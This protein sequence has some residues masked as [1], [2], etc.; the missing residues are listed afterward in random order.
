MI[1]LLTQLFTHI[2]FNNLKIIKYEM[3]ELDYSSESPCE[4]N[5][6]FMFE[7]Y[8]RGADLKENDK[9]VKSKSLKDFDLG[10]AFKTD[11][12]QG[13]KDTERA[14]KASQRKKDR[15]DSLKK[16]LKDIK[17]QLSSQ[18]NLNSTGLIGGSIITIPDP[19]KGLERNMKHNKIKANN[20][21]NVNGGDI[22]LENSYVVEY[23][24]LSKIAGE[25]FIEDILK[26][27]KNGFD[28]ENALNAATQIVT[29]NLDKFF[30]TDEEKNTAAYRFFKALRDNEITEDIIKGISNVTKE[31]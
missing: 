29:Q 5:M 28:A 16:D 19:G 22:T 10:K 14:E 2:F 31:E 11:E 25:D 15:Q 4:F 24:A 7:G 23:D 13:K 17:T 12:E 6:T 9:F 30:N 20:S 1:T 3:Y 18:N 8:A 27:S 21:L 26:E